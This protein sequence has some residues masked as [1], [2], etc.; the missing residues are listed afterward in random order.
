M[1]SNAD[2]LK[3]RVEKYIKLEEEALGKIKIT[4]PKNSFLKKIADDSMEMIKN[5]YAD[6]IYFYEK[7]DLLNAFAAL[8]YSYGWIDSGIRFGIF[9]GSGDS[10]LF[11]TY[12]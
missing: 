9:D 7:N 1:V 4:A 6:A 11:T 12:R 10:R 5:Y 3:E 8:N 2:D